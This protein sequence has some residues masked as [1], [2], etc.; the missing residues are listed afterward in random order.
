MLQERNNNNVMC[1]LV[2]E[3][4]NPA[5][6]SSI[7]VDQGHHRDKKPPILLYATPPGLLWT[8]PSRFCYPVGSVVFQVLRCILWFKHSESQ[9]VLLQLLR[10]QL[11][12]WETY[13]LFP[14]MLPVFLF[15]ST[16]RSQKPTH[17]PV[18]N[19][20]SAFLLCWNDVLDWPGFT[21]K[22]IYSYPLTFREK[23]TAVNQF[24]WL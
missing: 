10:S 3:T 8:L 19:I 15:P 9:A 14:A 16:L 18:Q 2:V 21:F 1:R 6:T 20:K 5:R 7:S 13:S 17:H 22:H 24:F 12:A 23:C 11:L 4:A